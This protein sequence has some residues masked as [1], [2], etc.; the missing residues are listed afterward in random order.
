MNNDPT[1]ENSVRKLTTISALILL[2]CA[3]LAR[4][5]ELPPEDPADYVRAGHPQAISPL[6][7]PS[8][9][10][11]YFGYYVGG[12][13]LSWRHGDLPTLDEGTWGWDYRGGLLKRR[14][15]LLWWHGRRYQGGSGA[16]KTD[17]PHLPHVENDGHE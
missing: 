17:G 8:N 1:K 16:Y 2:A 5:Q 14:V 7:R 13:A 4:G 15:N 3:K 11:R 9:N 10:H 6:A 12:G